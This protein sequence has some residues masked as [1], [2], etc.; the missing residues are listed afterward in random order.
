MIQESVNRL[1]TTRNNLRKKILKTVLSQFD[2]ELMKLDQK[3]IDEKYQKMSESPFR[4]FRGSAYLFY[5]DATNIPFT[6]HTLKEKP[7]WVQGDLHFENFGAFQNRK[8]TIV[9][10]V[11]DFDEGYLG[12]YLYE[13]LRMGTSIILFSEQNGLT[14]DDAKLLVEQYVSSYVE[15]LDLFN[16]K[17]ESPV[18]LSFTTNNTNGT[19]KKLLAKLEEQSAEKLINKLTISTDDGRRFIRNET[20]IDLA[21]EE[22]HGIEQE[23]KNYISSISKKNRKDPEFYQIKDIVIKLDSGTASIGLKR[24]YVLTAKDIVLEVKEARTPILAYFSVS[25][26]ETPKHNGERVVATQ[27]SMQYLE[28][29]YLGYFSAN[30]CELYVRERSPF[31]K[32][33]DPLKLTSLKKLLS[34]VTTMG[35]IT[36]KT[37][38]RADINTNKKLFTYES[39]AEILKA[40]GKNQEHFVHDLV[41]WSAYYARRVYL[42]HSLFKEWVSE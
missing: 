1:T 20:L 27:K 39:E 21:E 26:Y 10:D 34:V 40:I 6:Y 17:K 7:V 32:R 24:Y 3:S 41:S 36:A 37:H 30:D 13:I 23:W 14:N 31:K 16:R 8:E 15:Q 4:F 33:I 38:A 19:I 18:H 25:D 11:N 42:D 28:D 22:H 35:Q 9:Y 2:V 29:P 12:S 5:Y